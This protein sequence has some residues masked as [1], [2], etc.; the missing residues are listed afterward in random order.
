MRIRTLVTAVGLALGAW[1]C[2]S[3]TLEGQSRIATAPISLTQALQL[4]EDSNPGLRV[5]RAELAASEGAR[6]DANAF[7]Y[8]NPVLGFDGIHREVPVDGAFAERRREWAATMQQTLEIAGQPGYR[9]EAADASMSALLREIE[10]ARRQLYADVAQVYYRIL[11]LQQRV[12]LEEQALSLFDTTAAAVERRRTAGEDTRLDSNVAAVEADRARNQAALAKEQLLDARSDLAAKLQ[13]PE[14]RLPEAGGDL[15]SA[16]RP[17]YDLDALLTQA[18]LH[19]RLQALAA[20]EE[21]A[22]A[23]LKLE[24]AARYPDVT[25][26][27]GLGREGSSVARERLTTLTVSVPLPIFKQNAGNIG[28]A[29]SALTQAEVSRA[30]AVRDTQ[31]QVH[32]LWTKLL[33]LKARLDRTQ[34]RVL[35]ALLDN[36]QLSVKSQKAGQINLLELIVVNRQALDARRDLIDTLL[37]YQSTRI[38]LELAAGWPPEGVAP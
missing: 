18:A 22:R 37:D 28:Q 9:R 32:A 33:S 14:G 15:R 7:L 34:D 4:A 24:N 13:L 36:Q 6:T 11:A 1:Q 21:S 38:A 29:S 5:K 10:D 25:V 3:Q 2:F 23:K 30:A 12:D 35:P 16:P 17:H 26:G 20:R 8:N 31:A 19:P 27:L